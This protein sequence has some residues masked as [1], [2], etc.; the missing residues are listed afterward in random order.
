[1]S[2]RVRPS[3]TPRN[4]EDNYPELNRIKAGAASTGA[5]VLG[6]A[7][8]SI[9]LVAILSAIAFIICVFWGIGVGIASL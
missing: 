1:L 8:V 7:F 6:S 4:S 5:V 9:G 2:K 3:E